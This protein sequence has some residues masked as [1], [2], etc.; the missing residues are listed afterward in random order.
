[1]KSEIRAYLSGLMDG[2]GTIALKSN[3]S[4]PQWKN[5]NANNISVQLDVICNTNAALILAV[6]E[7]LK[8]SGFQPR[9]IGWQP[10]MPNSR[11]AYK[12]QLLSNDE[13]RRFLEYIHP[14]LVAKKQ[15]AE[16]VLEFLSRRKNGCKVKTTEYERLLYAK[17][18]PLNQRGTSESVTTSTPDTS[19]LVK[20]QSELH[21]DVQS[22]AEMTVPAKIN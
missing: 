9:T 12:V 16:I 21:G 6:V 3:V 19:N 5:K 2:E 17:L 11:R 18:K 14:Y 1:M 10:D 13:R 4:K 8:V 22:A 20:I 15:H 7:M